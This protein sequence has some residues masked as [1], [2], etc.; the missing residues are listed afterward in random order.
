MSYKQSDNLAKKRVKDSDSELVD[1]ELNSLYAAI[2]IP[3]F[4]GNGCF[5][6]MPLGVPHTTLSTFE[7]FIA[8]M[9]KICGHNSLHASGTDLH[10]VI[11]NCLR[12]AIGEN[13][14]F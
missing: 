11:M 14:N 2:F 8:A 6:D 1:S 5:S 10:E 13:S 4:I 12:T 7:Q 9:E 3:K